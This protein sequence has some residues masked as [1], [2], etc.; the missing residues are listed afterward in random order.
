VNVPI[1]LRYTL[2]GNSSITPWDA[3]GNGSATM[4]LEGN[5]LGVWQFTLNYT[6]F[7]GN[8]V[9]FVDYAPLLT[10]G[11]AMYGQGNALADRDFLA[12]SLRRTF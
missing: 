5:Y 10:G 8:A 1:G 4:G 9:P 7:I 3:K 6:H 2:D 12:F 11:S